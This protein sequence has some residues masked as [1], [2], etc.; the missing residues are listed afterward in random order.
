[1]EQE[2]DG[3]MR[4]DTQERGG[5]GLEKGEAGAGSSKKRERGEEGVRVRFSQANL[6]ERK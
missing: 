4:Q 2:P 5:Q 3:H 1:M 6:K